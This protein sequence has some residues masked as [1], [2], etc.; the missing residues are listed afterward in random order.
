[1][2]KDVE[3]VTGRNIAYILKLSGYDDIEK[4]NLR[5]LSRTIKFETMK[6]EEKWKLD[7]IQE[8]VNIKKNVLTLDNMDDGLDENEFNDIIYYLSTS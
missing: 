8:V 7:M 5:D 1:M 4:I 3:T 6:K 2:K